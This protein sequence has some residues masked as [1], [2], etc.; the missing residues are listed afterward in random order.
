MKAV[1]LYRRCGFFFILSVF[2]FSC[3]VT[4]KYTRQEGL[5]PANLYRD[6]A[7]TDSSNLANLSWK[8]LFTDSLLVSLIEEG[9]ANNLDLKIAVARIRTASANFK[10]SNLESSLQEVSL[11]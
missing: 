8:E 9:I 7:H 5:T 10:Q 4:Q 3:R 1:T 6:S 2:V 11:C